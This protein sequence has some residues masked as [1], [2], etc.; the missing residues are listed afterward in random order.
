MLMRSR[1]ARLRLKGSVD[2][3]ED[4]ERLVARLV[5][6]DVAALD[7]LY[8]RYSGAVF[9]LTVR[10][11]GD[12]PVAEELLQETFLRAWQRAGTYRG[13]RGRF[14]AWLLGIAH[15]LAID[16]LR[17]RRRRP[18]SVGE[19]EDAEREVAELPDPGPD[20]ADEAWAH[21]RRAQIEEALGQLPA[22]Q[23]VAIEL[24]YF[25]GLSQAEIAGRLGEPLGTV[26][27][28]IRLGLRKLREIVA[29]QGLKL[30]VD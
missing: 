23:R 6:G 8:D 14:A 11:V 26:K 27:T 2:W 18:Q 3:T 4:D 5:A 10:I 16:E 22:P 1:P 15:N 28:R 24:A 9:A 13:S 12:R 17:R 21:L 25:E 20:V 29:A 30:E 7:T 19:R